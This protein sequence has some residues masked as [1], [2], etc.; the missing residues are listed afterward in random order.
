MDPLTTPTSSKRWSTVKS[1]A[2][3][4]LNMLDYLT[5]EEKTRMMEVV[6]QR[7]M[8]LADDELEPAYS[9]PNTQ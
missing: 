7:M 5:E 6:S 8:V 9:F 1:R 4:E 2:E 3:K